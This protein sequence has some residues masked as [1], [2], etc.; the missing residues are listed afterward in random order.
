MWIQARVD[1]AFAIQASRFAR[2]FFAVRAPELT[3][4]DF[5]LPLDS[6]LRGNDGAAIGLGMH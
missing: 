3:W 6:R 5:V 2:P 4:I 1:I